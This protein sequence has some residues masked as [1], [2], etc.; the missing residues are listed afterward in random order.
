MKWKLNGRQQIMASED[1][2]PLPLPSFSLTFPLWLLIE[3][4]HINVLL[5]QVNPA[6][7][8][9]KLDRI[10][11][12][13][14]RQQMMYTLHVC[15]T[16]N[17]TYTSTDMKTWMYTVH[18]ACTVHGVSAY[19][20]RDM[21]TNTVQTHAHTTYHALLR[22]HSDWQYSS[23]NPGRYHLQ[24]HAPT[25]LSSSVCLKQEMRWKST[26]KNNTPTTL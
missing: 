8:M 13:K 25:L 22:A 2:H 3:R 7:G 19:T 21:K 20:S 4:L 16:Y 5:C 14:S 1:A 12:F 10:H 9:S 26:A 18:P 6:K 15:C 17:K 23:P 24:V 11:R